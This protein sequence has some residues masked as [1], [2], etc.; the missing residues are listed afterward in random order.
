LVLEHR[1][2]RLDQMI[3]YHQG[4]LEAL[5]ILVYPVFPLVQ[6]FLQVQEHLQSQENQ[7][8]LLNLQDQESLKHPLV[9]GFQVCLLLLGYL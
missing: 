5:V 7:L 9:P 3:L 1:L 2:F 6:C 8:V 4:L